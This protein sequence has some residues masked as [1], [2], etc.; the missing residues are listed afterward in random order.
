MCVNDEFS[1]LWKVGAVAC[2]KVQVCHCSLYRQ[3]T[4]QVTSSH[5]IFLIP[6]LLFFSP[7]CAQVSKLVC[8]IEVSQT[9]FCLHFLF[10]SCELDIPLNSSLQ[11]FSPFINYVIRINCEYTDYEILSILLLFLFFSLALCF[12]THSICV[13]SSELL[14]GEEFCSFGILAELLGVAVLTPASYSRGLKLEY[15]PGD[16]LQFFVV[17][18]SPSNQSFKED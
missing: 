6:I 10:P 14:I 8:F 2:F 12:Q 18:I 15:R 1:S 4:V 13:S 3:G 5:F 9:Q 11:S 7:I 17:F 16:R